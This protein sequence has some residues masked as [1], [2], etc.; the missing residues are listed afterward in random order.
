MAA[1]AAKY[2]ASLVGRI[3]PRS[4]LIPCGENDAVSKRGRQT[5]FRQDRCG[6]S[7]A[8]YSTGRVGE[9]PATIAGRCP[10]R[11]FGDG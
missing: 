9:A 4:A 7:V 2:L 6:E 11:R 8:L 3:V 5:P 1:E 10:F